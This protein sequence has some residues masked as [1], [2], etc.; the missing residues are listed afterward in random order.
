MARP[1]KKSPGRPKKTAQTTSATKSAGSSALETLATE[2][3]AFKKENPAKAARVPPSIKDQAKKLHDGGETYSSIAEACGVA[4]GSARAW[5]EGPAS[6]ATKAK[7]KPGRKPTAE[8]QGASAGGS[9][10][11]VKIRGN[12]V[13]VAEADFLK[14][15]K[16]GLEAGQ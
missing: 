4:L 8:R 3:R 14:L 11:R 16:G 13:Q 12:E 5:I 15:L 2:Y 10:V 7:G 6:K 1:K 9:W